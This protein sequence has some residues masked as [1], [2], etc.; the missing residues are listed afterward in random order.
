MK[1]CFDLD[2]TLVG[3]DRSLRPQCLNVLKKLKEDGNEI[4][5]WSYG[6]KTWAEFWNEHVIK[7]PFDG[8]FD[9]RSYEFPNDLPKIDL[10]TDNDGIGVPFKQLTYWCE[11]YVDKKSRVE[12]LEEMIKIVKE[13]KEKGGLTEEFV[14]VPHIDYL[15]KLGR[16]R[17]SDYNNSNTWLPWNSRK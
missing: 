2:G 15:F 14:N 4:Y 11:E 1:I 10:C 3:E 13:L 6:G 12:N 9:K 7:F 8:I 17:F 5:L 16:L